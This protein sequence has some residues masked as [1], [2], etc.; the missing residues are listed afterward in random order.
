MDLDTWLDQRIEQQVEYQL[1]QRLAQER[2]H[3]RCD[4]AD[5]IVKSA[6]E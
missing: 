3:L 6:S 1:E 5:L 4:V 2:E